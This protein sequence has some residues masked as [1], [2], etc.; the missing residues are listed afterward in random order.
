MGVLP[1]PEEVKNMHGKIE[2]M[3]ESLSAQ[4]RLLESIAERLDQLKTN[5]EQIA[6][7]GRELGEIRNC[8]T[9]IKDSIRFDRVA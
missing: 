8:L 6:E 4:N 5:E 9:V 1:V 7:I 3:L 2:R